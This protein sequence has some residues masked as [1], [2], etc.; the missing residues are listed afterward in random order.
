MDSFQKVIDGFFDSPAHP[1]FQ[2]DL[3]IYCKSV[4]S[5]F[6][7]C[8]QKVVNRYR[9]C[10]CGDVCLKGA[11][12]CE[13]KLRDAVKCGKVGKKCYLTVAALKD[14]SRGCT[15]FR[16]CLLQKYSKRK[17]ENNPDLEPVLKV[18]KLA[19]DT[20]RTDAI[21]WRQGALKAV[22]VLDEFLKQD[23][24]AEAT[25]KKIVMLQEI[26]REARQRKEDVVARDVGFL[27][28]NK[29]KEFQ[30]P[31]SSVGHYRF[32]HSLPKSEKLCVSGI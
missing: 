8:L 7:D 26:E 27:E 29:G 21:L 2:V 32:V 31:L 5:S 9:E 19:V 17:R 13:Y 1:Q 24:I 6:R 23:D 11:D 10:N 3:D 4:N 28:P 22:E 16:E 20:P 15:S 14:L 25:K 30:P 12:V 18:R